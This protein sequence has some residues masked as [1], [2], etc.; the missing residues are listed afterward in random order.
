MQSGYEPSFGGGGGGG[1]GGRGFRL[2]ANMTSDERDAQLRGRA[3]QLQGELSWQAQMKKQLDEEKRKKEELEDRLME[4]NMKRQQERMKA[5]YE[6][7]Q[8]KR[9]RKEEEQTRRREAQLKHMERLQQEAA[10]KKKVQRARTLAAADE[11]ASSLPTSSRHNS[12]DARNFQ[13]SNS[14]QDGKKRFANQDNDFGL[15][16]KSDSRLLAARAPNK[17]FD[18]PTTPVKMPRTSDD[19]KRPKPL[20]PAVPVPQKGYNRN[21]W[22]SERKH[23]EPRPPVVRGRPFD[24]KIHIQDMSEEEKARLEKMSEEETK[25]FAEENQDLM[26]QLSAMKVNL[27]SA[28]PGRQQGEDGKPNSTGKDT[29]SGIGGGSS[30]DKDKGGQNTLGSPTTIPAGSSDDVDY[31]RVVS[32]RPDDKNNPRRR[33]P[34]YLDLNDSSGTTIRKFLEHTRARSKE[35]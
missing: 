8:E 21:Q 6:A 1:G 17:F 3:E 30:P 32:G 18:A 34:S 10:E 29:D 9:R 20:T 35:S 31:L 14:Q 19:R 13:N 15:N 16:L 12:R 22:E 24:W 23:E 33:E 2:H 26:S 4:E 5:E 11:A 27:R 7:E 28:G 25:H